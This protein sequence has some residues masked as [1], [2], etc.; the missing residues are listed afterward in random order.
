MGRAWMITHH[1]D[2]AEGLGPSEPPRGPSS[3]FWRLTNAYDEFGSF[4]ASAAKR[5]A[6]A[7][8]SAPDAIRDDEIAPATNLEAASW[9]DARDLAAR[10]H[11]GEN[12]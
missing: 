8:V 5:A 6:S 11:A 1:S 10:A 2:R 3:P 4:H 12:S 9:G 7:S